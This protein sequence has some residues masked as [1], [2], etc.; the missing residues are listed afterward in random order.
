MTGLQ[1]PEEG[2]FRAT[3]QT[4]GKVY[5][6]LG[7]EG[8]LWIEDGHLCQQEAF[9]VNVVDTTEQ[10]MFFTAHPA[11]ALAEKM[12]TKEA[13]RFASAVAAMKCTQRR[14]GRHSNREQTESFLSLYA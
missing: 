4:A 12:P 3:T 8:S 6:T 7:S 13:I 9:S 10:A 11:V 14:S 5:V 2:L 1:S